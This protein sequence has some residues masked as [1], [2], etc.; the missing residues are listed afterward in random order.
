MKWSKQP[1][2]NPELMN[3]Q[4]AVILLT[5]LSGSGKTTLAQALSK[6]IRKKGATPVILDGDDIRK[7]FGTTGFDEISRKQHNLRVGSLAAVLEEQGH[8]VIIA[9]IAPYEDVRAQM[10]AMCSRF[11][12]VYLST[13]LEVCIQR[14]PKDLY[15]KAISGEIKDFTG[16][17]APYFPPAKPDLEL[18][19]AELGI[20]E[21]TGMLADLI[22]E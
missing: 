2:V 16:V 14:D 17:S 10:K 8:V 18:N 1:K 6:V 13:P 9:L 4:P 21:C 22:F 5:G 11:F 12:E 3:L 20:E 15:K 19:T 7:I